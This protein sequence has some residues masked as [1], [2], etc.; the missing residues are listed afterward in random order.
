MAG[1]F[2]EFLDWQI[3]LQAVAEDREEVCLLDIFFAIKWLAGVGH[4]STPYQKLRP[5]QGPVSYV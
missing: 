3:L 4:D 5:A 1:L 2:Q